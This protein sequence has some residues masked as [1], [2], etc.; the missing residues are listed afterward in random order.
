MS[1]QQGHAGGSGSDRAPGGDTHLDVETTL[2]TTEE[3]TAETTL[4][5]TAEIAAETTAENTTETTLE[6]PSPAVSGWASRLEGLAAARKARRRRVANRIWLA[7]IPV[8]VIVI[9]VM[10]LLSLFGGLGGETV[11]VTTTTVPSVP[12]A[13]SGLLLVEEGDSVQ[14][15]VL[16]QPWD[17]GGAVLG[18]PGITLVE[19][20]GVFQT[21][22]EVFLTD[23]TGGVADR[24]S[25]ALAM[26]IGP[27]ATV[28]WAA[29]RAGMNSAGVG[30]VPEGGLS[31]S[32]GAI[33]PVVEALRTFVAV[34]VSGQGSDLW[35]GLKLG[36]NKR[37][38]I[39]A[40]EIDARSMA[41]IDWEA[42]E[43]G[44]TVVSG[45]GFVYLEADFE[46]ARNLLGTLSLEALTSVEVKDGAGVIGAAARAADI[47][48]GAGYILL[49]MGYAES[50]PSVEVTQITV[51]PGMLEQGAAVR[52]LLGTGMVTEDGALEASHM[53]LILGADFSGK[54]TSGGAQ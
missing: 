49:P 33:L 2:E 27:S 14:L 37:G 47:L 3:T 17:E 43:L 18:V 19:G 16:L 46:E 1:D 48:E 11:L 6:S 44:G 4:E 36:G 22:S 7:A 54:G 52:T 35:D 15:A 12:A 31:Y 38:F 50:F 53:V 34:H 10:V 21:I 39:D 45:D 42:T 9:I 40:V 13:G 8:V 41:G 24:L 32:P 29:L 5:T 26:P 51:A 25:E 20:G 28:D 30:G 23:G